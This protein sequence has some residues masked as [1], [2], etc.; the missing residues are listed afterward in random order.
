[1]K[2]I[3]LTGGIATGKST[4]AQVLR[5]QGC[6]VIDADQLARQAVA[7]GSEG[8]QRVVRVFGSE[9]LNSKGDLDRNR[10]GK[11]VFSDPKLRDELEKIIHPLVRQLALAE[12]SRLKSKGLDQAFYDVPLL[13]EKN[14]EALFD[15]VLLVYAPEETQIE[16]MKT[17]DGFS[18]KEARKRL[19]AQVPIE[20]KKKRAG[21]VIENTGTL[22]DLE[23]NIVEY[24]RS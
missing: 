3:G 24:L 7:K 20:E 15:Q 18:E 14:L 17:R 2:W 10:L 4:V 16:R 11:A 1:M 13:F 22:E 19:A 23:R 9:V 5:A 8:F 6:S 12:K 21:T